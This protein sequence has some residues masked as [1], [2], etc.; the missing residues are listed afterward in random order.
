VSFVFMQ[1][2]STFPL[3]LS[4]LSIGPKAYGRIIALNGV[5]VVLFQVPMTYLV[6]RFN[7]ANVIVLA[8]LLTGIG[9][10]L[11]G[12]ASTPTMFALIVVVWTTGELMQSPLVPSIVSDLAPPAL[13]ARYFGLLSMCFSG[14][15][16][17]A[18]PLGGWLLVRFGG[19]WLWSGCVVTGLVSAGLYFSVRRRLGSSLS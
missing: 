12:L 11:N 3:Y 7:R 2:M 10:G 13:R 4:A 17:V 9:F 18:A 15:N 1:A 16:L 19:G 5:L 14:G 8:A 6:G